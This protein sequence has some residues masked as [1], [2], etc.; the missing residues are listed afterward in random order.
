MVRDAVGMPVPRIL[1][2]A[3]AGIKLDK[4]HPVL[5]QTAGQ[6]TLATKSRVRSLSRPYIARV[7]D[8]FA[9]QVD[10]FGGS[11]SAF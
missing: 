5:K 1:E 2:V 6:Q 3:A 7:A 9:F 11:S 8:V 4:A 10:H